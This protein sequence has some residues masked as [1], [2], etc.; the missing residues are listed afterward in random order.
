MLLFTLPFV[1]QAQLN[2]EID[3]LKNLLKNS[4][5]DTIQVNIL[6]KI[7]Y[8][9][10]TT[11]SVNTFSYANQATEKAK[12]LKFKPGIA[13]SLDVKGNFFLYKTN[14]LKALPFFQES[15]VIWTEL[16]DENQQGLTYRNIGQAYLLMQQYSNAIAALEKA[17]KIFLKTKNQKGLS[18]T[19]H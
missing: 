11:D 1:A 2:K 16:K 14:P 13:G 3:S 7:A 12:L 18:A 17:E 5:L 10:S 6:N 19:Y 4:R 9:Y 15:I 8:R